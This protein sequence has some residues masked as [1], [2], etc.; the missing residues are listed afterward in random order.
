M[1]LRSRDRLAVTARQR[2]R[3]TG[4]GD[5]GR[6]QAAVERRTRRGRHAHVR[7]RAG[8][9]DLGTPRGLDLL[10][11]TGAVE[12]V[13]IALLDHR[14]AGHRRHILDQPEKRAG[15]IEDRRAGPGLVLEVEHRHAVGTRE[16]QQLFGIRDG[17]VELIERQRAGLVFILQI[18]HQKRGTGERRRRL[19]CAGNLGQ[20]LRCSHLVLSGKGARR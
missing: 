19:R 8:N 7:H 11:Q 9:D 4:I 15:R 2:A 10:F 16:H 6:P 12:A 5:D 18:D 17:A 14:F 3:G 1:N 20:G 13:R